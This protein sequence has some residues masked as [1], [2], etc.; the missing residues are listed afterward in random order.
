MSAPSLHIEST[1]SMISTIF[2]HFAWLSQ[3]HH[4]DHYYYKCKNI[5]IKMLKDVG[6]AVL[7]IR[8]TR[9]VYIYAATQR[10]RACNN[11][12]MRNPN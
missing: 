8:K 5:S 10:M 12:N 4:N 11:N 6:M 2:M 1:D 3:L 9:A 7:K